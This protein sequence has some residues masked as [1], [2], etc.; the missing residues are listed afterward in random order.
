MHLLR[1]LSFVDRLGSDWLLRLER[2]VVGADELVLH[3]LVL[4]LDRILNFQID[5]GVFLRSIFVLNCG[6][7]WDIQVFKRAD[8]ISVQ[9]GVV[10]RSL[11]ILLTA[12]INCLSRLRVILHKYG[13]HRQI[14][15][16][17]RFWRDRLQ[18]FIRLL[19]KFLQILHVRQALNLIQFLTHEYLSLHRIF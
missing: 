18:Q 7:I 1:T 10:F 6:Y 14:L 5:S 19:T 9:I 16:I 13:C 17:D 3:W 11:K 2:N 15:F 8:Q 4:A 12:L